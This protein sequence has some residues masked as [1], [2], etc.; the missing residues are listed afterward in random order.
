MCPIIEHNIKIEHRN[1]STAISNAD[2][3]HNIMKQTKL[4]FVNSDFEKQCLIGS[5][6]NCLL[7]KFSDNI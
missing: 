1:K 4:I 5:F 7:I 6:I 2:F 3:D